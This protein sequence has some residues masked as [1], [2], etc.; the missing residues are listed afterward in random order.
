MERHIQRGNS[1]YPRRGRCEAV[2]L[3]AAAGFA[4]LAVIRPD[5]Y[6]SIARHFAAAV[7]VLAHVLR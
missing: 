3:T 5:L 1:R 6:G 7:S 2:L 4:V